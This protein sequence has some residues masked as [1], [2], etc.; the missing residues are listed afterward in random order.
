MPKTCL[1]HTNRRVRKRA[2]SIL[3]LVRKRGPL[4]PSFGVTLTGEYTFWIQTSQIQKSV[5]NQKKDLIMEGTLPSLP[6][7]FFLSRQ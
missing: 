1:C 3:L 7:I 4:H 6:L 5:S 2:L